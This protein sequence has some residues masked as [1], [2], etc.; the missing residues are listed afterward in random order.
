LNRYAASRGIALISTVDAHSEDDPEFRVW[1][2]HC[3]AGTIGQ[4]K[5]CATLLEHRTVVPNVKAD[6]DVR[7]AKQI[8]LEKQTTDCFTNVNIDTLLD[9]L[10]AY[11]CYVYGVVTEICVK[12]AAFGLLRRGKPVTIVTDA[13]ECLDS[14]AAREMYAEFQSKGGKLTTASELLAS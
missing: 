5:P 3:V 11:E 8:V 6:Y 13:V 10:S 2:H 12:N 9:S 1:P 4:T 14:K 7:Q